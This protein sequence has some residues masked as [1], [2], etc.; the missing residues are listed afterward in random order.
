MFQST[1]CSFDCPAVSQF[2]HDPRIPAS[3][4][5]KKMQFL[6]TPRRKQFQFSK[7]EMT[8]HVKISVKRF[9]LTRDLGS[10]A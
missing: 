5:P 8:G 1:N 6:P 7:S 3:V 10:C 4:Q 2:S 9:K